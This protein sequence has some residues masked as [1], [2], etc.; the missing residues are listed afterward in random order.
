MKHTDN[1]RLLKR[2]ESLSD[3]DL[4]NHIDMLG[5]EDVIK[6]AKLILKDRKDNP[7]FVKS[8]SK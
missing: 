4:Q 2:L 1:S 8:K 3:E 6:V 5:D 7:V